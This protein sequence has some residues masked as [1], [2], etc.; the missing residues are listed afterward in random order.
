AAD[1]RGDE[2]LQS[3]QESGVVIQRRDRHDQDS[4]NRPD[5]GR[6]KERDLSRQRGSDADQARAEAIDGGGA[7]RLAVERKAEKQPQADD[8]GDGDGVDGDALAG[9]A[10]RPDSEGR[11]R[12]RRAALALG[13][14]T[15]QAKTL[16]R[17]R[18]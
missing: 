4:R 7:K 6:Q 15:N 13:A 17:Q 2:A 9:E 14:E 8:E 5:Q 11:I 3:D 10:Q 16:Q 18:A 12:N 1:D